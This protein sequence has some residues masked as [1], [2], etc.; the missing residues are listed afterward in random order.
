MARCPIWLSGNASSTT[1][2]TFL[3]HWAHQYRGITCSVTEG[4]ESAWMSSMI[5]HR[6]ELHFETLPEQSGHRS[7]LCVTVLS[8][9]GVSRR[10]PACPRWAPGFLRRPLVLGLRKVAIWPEGTDGSTLPTSPLNSATRLAKVRIAKMDASG[11]SSTMA[12]ASASENPGPIW[13]RT[14]SRVSSAS[15]LGM[16][17][18]LH[19]QVHF[20]TA[21]EGHFK[22][23]MTAKI[24]NH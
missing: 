22:Q 21:A 16:E 23:L 12:R 10:E 18:R 20:A 11:P 5:R 14:D 19:D 24:H 13:L 15:M 3:R 6:L 7:R 2:S 1:G 8:G 17:Q 4:L 9:L